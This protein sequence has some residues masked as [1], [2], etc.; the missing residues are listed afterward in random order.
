[1]TDH[2]QMLFLWGSPVAG[3]WEAARP[4]QRGAEVFLQL[5]V[6][7]KFPAGEGRGPD[8]VD[9]LL[10]EGKGEK[11]KSLTGWSGATDRKGK[12]NNS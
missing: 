12:G 6:R 5:Q 10:P 7:E 8:Q 9:V 2:G 4:E 11:V 3:D 1:M